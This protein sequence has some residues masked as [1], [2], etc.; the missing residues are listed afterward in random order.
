MSDSVGLA[1]LGSVLDR[2]NCFYASN[3]FSIGINP[4][5]SLVIGAEAA[6]YSMEVCR[7]SSRFG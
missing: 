3:M 1:R 6:N 2:F 7:F 4:A 5:K